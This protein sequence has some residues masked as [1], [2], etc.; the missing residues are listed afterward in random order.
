MIKK[1]IDIFHRPY[2]IESRSGKLLEQALAIGAFVVI[3]ILVFE[4]FSEAIEV[5]DRSNLSVLG[6][7][8]ITFVITLAANLLVSKSNFKIFNE[9]KWNVKKEFISVLIMIFFIGLGNALYNF[10]ET[11]TEFNFLFL[12]K[13]QVITLSVGVIPVL[14]LVILTYNR[15]LKQNLRSAQRLNERLIS[16]K[17][18]ET[19]IEIDSEN[20]NEIFRINS[21]N[22]HFI[23]SASNYVEVFY[24]ESGKIK[25]NLVRNS[26]K[27]IEEKLLDYPE[28][29]RCHRAYI[30]NL[31]T[32]KNIE[33][34][35]Q[36]Y[37]LHF[38]NSGHVVP[39]SRSYAKKFKDGINKNKRI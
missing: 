36:G 18:D 16:Q 15:I 35:S 33:G 21:K 10:L 38:E 39:V 5:E 29:I 11:G 24:L 30:V 8:L 31:K 14:F 17:E 37:I 19:V 20:K 1:I 27:K 12:M 22:L 13:F 26:L 28:L 6:Y 32:I 23:K 3:F 2:P 34:N 9:N 4:P 7:G 25:S